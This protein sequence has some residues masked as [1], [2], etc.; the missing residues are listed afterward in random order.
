M[1]VAAEKVVLSRFRNHRDWA[2]RDFVNRLAAAIRRPH[3]S[4]T[5]ARALNLSAHGL[6]DTSVLAVP[7]IT[8]ENSERRPIRLDPEGVSVG[9]FAGLRPTHNTAPKQTQSLPHICSSRVLE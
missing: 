9:R 3:F 7:S 8:I 4:R 5:S 6:L 2:A 1:A